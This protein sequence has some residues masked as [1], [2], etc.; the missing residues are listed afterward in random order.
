VV[1]IPWCGWRGYTHEEKTT[2]LD[3]S[4]ELRS[5][6]PVIGNV[7]QNLA[8]QA[9]VEGSRL[10]GKLGQRPADV[11]VTRI[12][13]SRRNGGLAEIHVHDLVDFLE[14]FKKARIEAL[15][16]SGVKHPAAKRRTSGETLECGSLDDEST[17]VEPRRRELADEGKALTKAS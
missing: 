9:T 4:S 13:P 7:L 6:S 2:V 16:A 10:E 5:R 12:L 1:F 8:A 15:T 14:A 11:P 17:L 3:A